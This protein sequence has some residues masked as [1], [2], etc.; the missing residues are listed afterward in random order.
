MQP[1]SMRRG[2]RLAA[3]ILCLAL[4]AP[5]PARAADT[6]T[7]WTLLADRLGRNLAN[8]RTTAI[9]HQ[10]MHDALNAA[11]PTYARWFPPEP[12]E[13]PAAGTI[14][15]AAM[16]AAA[17]QV[18]LSLHWDQRDETMRTYERAL[19]GMQDGPERQAG[20]RLG[21]AIGLAAVTRREN[22]GYGRIHPFSTANGPGQWRHVPPEFT[23]SNTTETR[24]FLSASRHDPAAPPPPAPGSAALVRDAEEVRRLGGQEGSDRT[25][26]QTD[27][28]Y[29]WAFQSS[30]RGFPHLAAA[31]LDQ[32]PR[33]GGVPEHARIMSQL[34]S[35]MADAAILAWAE[36]E[37]FSYWRPVTVLQEGGFGIEADPGWLPVIETPPHPD[38]PSGHATD[39]HTGAGVLSAVFGRL[40]SPVTYVAQTGVP[41]AEKAA[42]GMGQH[43]QIGRTTPSERR[44]PSLAAA[45]QECANS[46]IWAGAHFRTAN[47]EASRIADGIVGRALAAVPPLR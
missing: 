36:K 33:P 1:H 5:A 29:F 42:I 11:L 37:R 38:Y 18:L 2:L 44:F 28:A 23:G 4:L 13:P 16:I 21:A 17:T 10:A 14:P 19:G 25:P 32:H 20:V 24:P 47:N 39:C 12:N 46:R 6:V 30:Q 41:Q 27:A 3:F 15:Q 35:A 45:A 9:M 22:D 8:W 40:A 26:A 34:A 7:E 31:L 43:Q